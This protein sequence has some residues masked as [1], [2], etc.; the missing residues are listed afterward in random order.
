M[1]K[2]EDITTASP[3][4]CE[5][6]LLYLWTTSSRL[7]LGGAKK[8]REKRIQSTTPSILEWIALGGR[9]ESWDKSVRLMFAFGLELHCFARNTMD[10]MVKS[11]N[12][13]FPPIAIDVYGC[14]TTRSSMRFVFL[15]HETRAVSVLKNLFFIFESFDVIGLHTS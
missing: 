8:I 9:S 15:P 2:E 5:G 14:C 6:L 10:V 11:G 13:L 4:A 7:I 1:G 12:R 3:A